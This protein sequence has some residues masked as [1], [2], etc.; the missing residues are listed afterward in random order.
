MKVAFSVSRL[1][2]LGPVLV[3]RDLVVGLKQENIDCTVFYF[4]EEKEISMDCDTYRISFFEKIDFD[5]YDIIHSHGIR[6]DAYLYWHRFQIKHCKCVTT[7]HNY[8]YVDLAY[9][10]NKVVAVIFSRLWRFLLRKHDLIVTLSRNAM[11]YYERWLPLSKLAYVYNAKSVDRLM[12]LSENEKQILLDFKK[13][14]K[15]IGVNALL[16]ERKGVDQLIRVLP[17]LE[18]YVLVVVGDGQSRKELEQLSIDNKVQ[19]RCLFLGY[20]LNAFRFLQYYDV[21]G[22][23]SRSEGFPLSLIEASAYG[24]PTVCSRIP[25][26]EEIFTSEEVAFFTL[27]DIASLKQAIILI[28]HNEKNIGDNFRKAYLERYTIKRMTIGY[29]SLY[30]KICTE[31]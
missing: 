19:D 10:Y 23:V 21:Y 18:D 30:R 8:M 26:F 6:P 11:E 7:L 2:N 9:Q 22:M 5:A 17:E 27:N 28:E 25:I 15:I 3:V 4:D 16:T 31:R 1:V 12:D 29:L 20:Q 13:G 24:V 14:R